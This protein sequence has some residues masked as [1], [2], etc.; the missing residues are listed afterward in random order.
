M[1]ER[2][3]IPRFFLYGEAGREAEPDFLHIERI[4]LRSSQHAW[5]IPPHAHPDHHQI[6]L[7]TEGGSTLR[8]EAEQWHAP[9]PCMLVVPATAVHAL[10]SQPGTDG[11]VVTV[12]TSFLDAAVG[13]D[14]ELAAAVQ[15]AGAYG[16]SETEIEEH[17]LLGAF[18]WLEREFVWSAPGR[19]TA[20]TAH[21]QRIV[22]AL[23]RLRHE[24]RLAGSAGLRREAEL[25]LRYRELIEQHFRSALP[26]AF[27]AARLGVTHARLNAACRAVMGESALKLL[28]NR[29]IVEAQR[30]LL[31]TS[32][33]VAEV[34]YAVGFKDPAYFSRFFSHRA[35]MPPGEFRHA[36]G[37]AP[38]TPDGSA[39]HPP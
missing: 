5:T 6:L 13:H 23:A 22:V 1:P 8:V 38:A 2:N 17:G 7:V 4:R 11:F 26:L 30:N 35:G 39:A 16:L 3:V 29:V 21:L 24:R 10:D 18:R 12:A 37:R 15:G 9:A 32:M 27:F 34:A 28:H 33:T 19:R 14:A 20:I 36:R 25:V 31:Y